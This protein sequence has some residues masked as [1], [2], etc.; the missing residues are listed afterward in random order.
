MQHA[1]RGVS[2]ELHRQG[3]SVTTVPLTDAFA[4]SVIWVGETAE[5]DALMRLDAKGFETA[6][7]GRLDGLLGHIGE[8]GARAHFPVTRLTAESLVGPRTALVGEAG[9]VLPP[10][11]AQGLN[12]GLR[13]VATLADCVSTAMTRGGDPGSDEVLSA[14]D[15]ARKLDVLTRT[16]GI[17]LLS[18]S[19]LS[20]FLPIQAVRGI[21][22]Y[23]LNALPPLRRLVM[24]IGMEPPTELPSLMRPASALTGLPRVKAPAWHLTPGPR[25]ATRS[26]SP[27]ARTHRG[28]SKANGR[29]VCHLAATRPAIPAGICGLA[30]S[31]R[32]CAPLSHRCGRLDLGGDLA[33]GRAPQSPAQAR[34]RQSRARLPGQDAEEREQIALRMWG[35]LGRV[36]VETMNIDRI[37]KEPD[38]LHVTNG[39]VIGRYKDKMG[40]VLIVTMHMGNWELGMWP[41]MLAGVKPAGVYR[42]VK[43]PYVDRYL[44]AQRKDLYPG[45]LF[46]SRRAAGQDEGQKTARLIMDYVRQGGRL[47]FISDLYDAQGVEVPFFGYPAKSMPIA[48]MIARRVGARIWIGRCIRIGNRACFDIN[49]NE[50]R[51]PRT[52][53]QAEDIRSITAAIQ[54][55]FEGWIRE[56]PDQFMW[57]NRRWS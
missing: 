33:A 42:L 25:F 53:N 7:A 55:Q 43:N 54:R 8:I 48:A 21:V 3:G 47:G 31:D 51:I 24:R 13:D 46:G 50:L 18:R 17:D 26:T 23:G 49:V 15:R 38:R 10:I 2:I 40:P 5:I 35:N 39:H 28:T 52:N 19:L 1:H 11:G 27:H 57:S 30:H 41:V 22:S 6:L 56:N 16:L 37:L 45:G 29:S 44:R 20:G 12:L 36:M 4:S 9:H 34:A 32:L 14:Y